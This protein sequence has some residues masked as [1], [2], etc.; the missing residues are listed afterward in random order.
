MGLQDSL[1]RTPLDI[2]INFSFV[3]QANKKMS[4]DLLKKHCSIL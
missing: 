4:I 1:N 2:A 3:S